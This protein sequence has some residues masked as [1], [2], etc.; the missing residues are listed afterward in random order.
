MSELSMRS[1]RE[2]PQL[3]LRTNFNMVSLLTR[4]ATKYCEQDSNFAKLKLWRDDQESNQYAD[5]L[6]R[7]R[8]Q[9]PSWSVVWYLDP[10]P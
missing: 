1:L 8:W 6:S 4:D 9:I 7:L 2:H 3:E 10:P 5:G